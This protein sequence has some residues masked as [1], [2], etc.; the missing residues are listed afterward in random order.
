MARER[1]VV[2]GAGGISNAWFPPLKQEK[3]DV[4]GVVDLRIDAAKGQ[5]R[6]YE[7]DAVASTDL[8]ATLRKTRPDFVVDLTVPEAHCEVTCTALK[9]GCPEVGEKPMASSMA[10]ARRMVRT[11]QQTGKLYMVSQSRR[12]N[13]LHERVRRTVARGAVGRLTT[14]NCDFYIGAHFGGFRD[15]MPSPLIL[16]MSIH[17]FDLARFM[18][19]ANPVAVYARE[20]NPAG[21][22]Y[23]GDVAASCLFE[24]TDGVIFTYRGSWCAEGCH[25]S[26]N[27]D[28]R[29][30]GDQGTLLYDHDGEPVGEVVAG[31]AGFHLQKKPLK[32][33]PAS[34]KCDGMHG[35]LR[36]MLAFLRKGTVPQ[37]QCRDNIQSLAMVF[38]AIESSQKRRRVPVRVM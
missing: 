7:L 22:W 31:K 25:T 28:W 21:S 13:A 6:R 20:F 23:Q 10:E 1:A 8:K 14:V 17:H 16:D 32:V 11:A 26:W 12:W 38:A 3:V 18:T 19:G 30:I 24:M 5:I 2:V 36:E 9:A 34:M 4:A 29:I 33:S 27:G 35:A 37:T 15:K